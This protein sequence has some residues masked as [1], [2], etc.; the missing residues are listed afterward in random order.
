M[1]DISDISTADLIGLWRSCVQ[2]QSSLSLAVVKV[3]SEF[4]LTV[5]Q[6]AAESAGL[7]AALSLLACNT[8]HAWQARP[9]AH[10]D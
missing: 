4:A 8:P 1:L 2:P 5:V 6:P 9:D 7:S 10:R 3:K